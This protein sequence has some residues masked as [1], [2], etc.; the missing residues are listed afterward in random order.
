MKKRRKLQLADMLAKMWYGEFGRSEIR[1]DEIVIW[2]DL[3]YGMFV[4]SRQKGRTIAEVI[5]FREE[6]SYR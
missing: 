3:G 1:Y 4:S 5:R 2:I 6:R